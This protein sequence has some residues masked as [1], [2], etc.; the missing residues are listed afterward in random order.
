MTDSDL[1]TT[2]G[3]RG[4]PPLPP[5]GYATRVTDGGPVGWQTVAAI[6]WLAVAVWVIFA[7]FAQ[8]ADDNRTAVEM[9]A[10]M[11]YNRTMLATPWWQL[12]VPPV[13]RLSPGLLAAFGFGTAAAVG[14][15]HRPRV[16][17]LCVAV[18]PVVATAWAFGRWEADTLATR[19]AAASSSRI[20]SSVGGF[21]FGSGGVLGGSANLTT[22]FVIQTVVVVAVVQ[23]IFA[24]LG[25]LAGRPIARVLAAGLLPPGLRAAVAEL[26]ASR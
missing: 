4:A 17:L 16:R 23:A 21:G 24:Y 20:Y 3:S 5:L 1:R 14:L 7:A 8:F 15:P 6:A 22:L 25:T 13:V 18:V 10:R 12:V 9:Y 19:A 11:T 2:V 26:W